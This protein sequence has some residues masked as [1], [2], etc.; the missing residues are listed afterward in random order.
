MLLSRSNDIKILY[1]GLMDKTT[2][3]SRRIGGRKKCEN[4]GREFEA[5]RYWDKYCSNACGS[6]VRVRRF[7]VNKLRAESEAKK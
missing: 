3:R 1:N 7:W 6:S 2:G 4:C 5:F